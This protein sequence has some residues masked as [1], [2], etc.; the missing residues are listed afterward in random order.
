VKVRLTGQMSASRRAD[1][2]ERQQRDDV[3]PPPE[4]PA[5][6]PEHDEQPGRQRCGHALAEKG[7]REEQERRP[8]R[9]RTTGLIELQIG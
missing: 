7:Q 8:V 1:A 3:L 5:L 6:P 9:R 2:E 4:V